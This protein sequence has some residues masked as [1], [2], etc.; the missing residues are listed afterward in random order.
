MIP[1]SFDPAKHYFGS[2][3]K[4]NH[5]YDGQGKSLRYRRDGT[6]VQ[7]QRE[8]DQARPDRPSG[9]NAFRQLR[10]NSRKRG[11][12]QEDYTQQ[13]LEEL[14]TAYGHECAYCGDDIKPCPCCR[15]SSHTWDHF[16][17][18]GIDGLQNL[19]PACWRCNSIKNNHEPLS[20][21]RSQSFYQPERERRIL[22]F[23]KNPPVTKEQTEKTCLNCGEVSSR[24]VKCRCPRCY[25]YMLRRGVERPEKLWGRESW[26]TGRA[27]RADNTPGLASPRASRN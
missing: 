27:L 7:C 21:F 4:R 11:K 14:L 1:A 22:N 2:V 9:S 10:R 13:Q 25:Q 19:V 20:W 23:L 3:C 26:S 12:Q 6:C 5:D 24:L 16:D 8:R 17:P 15:R 18:K